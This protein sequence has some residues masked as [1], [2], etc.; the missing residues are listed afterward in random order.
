[1]LSFVS[2]QDDLSAESDDDDVEVSLRLQAQFIGG[3][4]GGA[5]APSLFLDQNEAEK[6]VFETAPLPP[7]PPYLKVW[8]R[9]CNLLLSLIVLCIFCL[10]KY[11][12][13]RSGFLF[14]N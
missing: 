1:M 7:S 12:Y 13:N 14:I 6:T 4:T 3:S 10:L 5:W 9:H 8:I 11:I 2:W